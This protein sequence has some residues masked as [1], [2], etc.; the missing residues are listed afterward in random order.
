MTTIT[1]PR[2]GKFINWQCAYGGELAQSSAFGA[3]VVSTFNHLRQWR[4][5]EYIASYSGRCNL[6]ING[7]SSN[8]FHIITRFPEQAGGGDVPLIITAKK[9][10]L[11]YGAVNE[12]WEWYKD[13]TDIA[14]DSTLYTSPA[15]LNTVTDDTANSKA[16]GASREF[17][18]DVEPVDIATNDG[19]RC[20]RL[21]VD[22]AMLHRLNVFG[23]PLAATLDED[24]AVVSNLDVS[25]GQPLRGYVDGTDDGTVGA[26]AHY[27]D[28]ED[29]CIHNTARC[30]F[31]TPYAKGVHLNDEAILIPIRSDVNGVAMTY[32]VK[33]RNLTGGATDIA[34]DIALVISGDE[35]AAVKFISNTA[36]DSS[37]I[38][39][40]AGGYANPTL[41][42]TSH[43]ACEGTL[44]IDPDGD[45]IEIQA[46]SGAGNDIYIH[47]VSLWEPYK[48]R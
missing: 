31:Q 41:I 4:A 48:N 2:V 18:A 6:A 40:P 38:T 37:T 5:G 25:A 15:T 19:F 43:A 7:N 8:E 46:L 13:Y 10:Q 42:T 3:P 14:A 12:V 28:A 39:I 17:A 11:G 21:D 33:P 45:Y 23:C 29:S 9:W 30:L 34:C 22:N 16:H 44:N 32:K 47:T 1:N 36:V 26:V 24:E 35:E 27:I 20:S